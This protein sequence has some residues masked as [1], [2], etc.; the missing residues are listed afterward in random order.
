MD[1][2]LRLPRLVPNN[3]ITDAEQRYQRQS[4]PPRRRFFQWFDRVGL[5]L[6]LAAS[7]ILFG[8][9]LIA[10]L[11]GR[12]PTPIIDRLGSIP[13]YVTAIVTLWQFNLLFRT[14]QLSSSSIA[15]EKEAQ[16]WELLVLSGIDAR[17]IVRGKWWATVQR[18]WSSFVWLG[19]ARL[20]VV[21]LGGYS[22]VRFSSYYLDSNIHLPHPAS[23]VL[24]G[25]VVFVLTLAALAFT[26]ACGIMGSAI[27]QRSAFALVRAIAIQI[28]LSLGP[29]LL[30]AFTLFLLVRSSTFY[31]SDLYSVMTGTA[32]TLID[33]GSIL[34]SGLMSVLSPVTRAGLIISNATLE[35]VPG[36]LMLAALLSLL[37]YAMLTWLALRL[38]ERRAV[39][40][41]ALPV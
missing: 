12:D 15:R 37:M 13:T 35:V 5:V 21:T 28:V 24:G 7:W 3:P 8:G 33:N 4:T 38:A 29:G 9:L 32:F 39:S 26:A 18:Q 30:A 14:L 17:R 40:Q 34:A 1:Y 36:D 27:S 16:T 23:V 22:S 31:S 11:A 19:L 25:V 2:P 10:S 20:G 6:I 41:M